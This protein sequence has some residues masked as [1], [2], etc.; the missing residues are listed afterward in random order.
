MLF[1]VTDQKE[2]LLRI[3]LIMN[4]QVQKEWTSILIELTYIKYFFAVVNLG[5]KS[6]IPLCLDAVKEQTSCMAVNSSA[7]V[8]RKRSFA[9][10]I[11]LPCHNSFVN[12]TNFGNGVWLIEA[13][14][15]DAS[16]YAWGGERGHIL[17]LGWVF[18][19]FS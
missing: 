18:A 15:S 14:L 7:R 9:M 5:K 8:G 4:S 17:L 3:S 12:A 6:C 1:F 2:Y 10:V 19:H 13:G 11:V 16:V